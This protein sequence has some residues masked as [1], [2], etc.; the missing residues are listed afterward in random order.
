MNTNNLKN[1]LE[2]H[3]SDSFED[4][5]K[6]GA[7]LSYVTPIEEFPEPPK[8]MQVY[9]SKSVNPLVMLEKCDTMWYWDKGSLRTMKY[10]LPNVEK[11]RFYMMKKLSGIEFGNEIYKGFN[12]IDSI[13]I[14]IEKFI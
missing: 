4:R 13:A 9:S 11:E 5:K 12:I 3:L 7:C 10:V 14:K 8:E 2:K 6:T 1:K